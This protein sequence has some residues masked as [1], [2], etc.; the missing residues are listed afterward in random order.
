DGFRRAG[1]VDRRSLSLPGGAGDRSGAGG[2][3]APLGRLSAGVAPADPAAP[4]GVGCDRGVGAGADR[5]ARGVHVLAAL[6][7]QRAGG[8]EP[9]RG[10]GAPRRGRGAGRRR[11][12]R[13]RGR[14]RVPLR[15]GSGPAD[16]DRAGSAYGP[17]RGLL[18]SQRPGSPRVPL[19]GGGPLR[20]GGIAGAGAAEGDRRCLQLRGSRRHRPRRLQE[21][22]RLVPAVRGPLRDGTAGSGL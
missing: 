10:G 5:A 2:G 18:D 20:R 13:V 6:E 3:S 17:L 9:A 21:R 11:R 8:G 22:G 12:R 1:A 16:R 19:A 7:P 14:R 4:A 15:G